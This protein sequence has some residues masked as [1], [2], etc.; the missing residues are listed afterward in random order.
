MED[1]YRGESP[2]KKYARYQCWAA[3]AL[4][5]GAERFIKGKHLVLA[6]REGGDIS[7]LTGLEV[8]PKNIVA[9]EHS[10][11]AAYAVQEKYPNI[12]VVCRDVVKMA[13][14]CKRT[15]SSAYLDFCG[16]ATDAM[17][18]RVEQVIV[19]GLKDDAYIAVTMLSGREQGELRDNILAKKAI[20]V[21]WRKFQTLSDKAL[22][23]GMIDGARG[24]QDDVVEYKARLKA[25]LLDPVATKEE[26]DR[27]R[28]AQTVLYEERSAPLVRMHYVREQLLTRLVPRRVALHPTE[29]LHY[30]SNTAGANGVPMVV[31]IFKTRR[32][33]RGTPVQK[34]KAYSNRFA[35]ESG[36]TLV[37]N[38]N[39]NDRELRRV[40]LHLEDSIQADRDAGICS[41]AKVTTAE[42]LALTFNLRPET[43][44]AWKAH[45][46]RGTYQEEAEQ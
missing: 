1:T 21:E 37:I 29:V 19:H 44:I 10:S 30:N 35:A 5:M 2:S 39:M 13:Q 28:V 31:V 14:E 26:A 6:S 45:R 23:V 27:I 17:L 43:I 22:L 15:L 7:T 36:S 40:V 3:I 8:E 4:G 25:A 11:S 42:Q 18:Q 16:T 33:T 12:R 46:T 24:A 20:P 9:V 34:F 41:A 38:C 32:F